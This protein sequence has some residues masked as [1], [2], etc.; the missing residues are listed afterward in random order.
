MAPP[1]I[2]Y[3]EA[4]VAN[5]AAETE[6]H[7]KALAEFRTQVAARHPT[8]AVETGLMSIDGKVEPLG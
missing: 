1:R 5:P 3:G 8:L 2:A 4:A 6:T 7:R